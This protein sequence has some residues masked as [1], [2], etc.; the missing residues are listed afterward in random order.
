MQNMSNEL[1]DRKEIQRLQNEFCLAT[2]VGVCCLDGN[3]KKITEISGT[4]E[5]IERI[6]KYME[7]PQVIQAI[8]RIQEGFLED[9]AVEELNPEGDRVAVAAVRVK[10]VTLCNWVVFSL[11]QDGGDRSQN[12]LHVVDLLRDTS[13]ALYRHKAT[14]F[15]EDIDSHI[16]RSAGREMSRY[17][18]TIE[19]ADQMIQLL[20]SDEREEGILQKWLGILSE[21][22]QVDTAQLYQSNSEDGTMDVLCEWLA[23]G[24]MSIYDR[25]GKLK[26]PRYLRTEKPM[27]ISSDIADAKLQKYLKEWKLLALIQLPVIRR[28][29]NE[30]IMLSLNHRKRHIWTEQ[31]IQFAENAVR[32]LN[33]ILTVRMQKNKIACGRQT[34]ET[35]MDNVGSAVYVTDRETGEMLFAN[36]RLQSVFGKELAENTFEGMLQQRVSKGLDSSFFEVHQAQTERWYDLIVKE[37]VWL[38]GKDA[39][40]YALYDITDKKLFQYRIEQ[41]MYMDPMTGLNNRMCCERD[42]AHLIDEAKRSGS[43]GALLYMDLD[44]F[45][46]INDGLGHRYGDALLKTI[47]QALRRVSGVENTCYRMGGDEFVILIPPEKYSEYDRIVNDICS[48]FVRPWFLKEADYYCTMSMGSVIFPDQGDSVTELIKKAD[49]SMYEAKKGGKNRIVNYNEGLIIGSGWRLDM[50]KNMRDATVE[51]YDEFEVYF[52]PIIDVQNGAQC[53]G[54]E[55]LIRWNSEK[56]GF[57]SPTEFIPL[58]EYLG[59]INPIGNYV[60]KEACA[61]CRKWNESGY[62]EY[63]VNVNLSVVQLLQPDVV[64][65]VE[66]TIKETGINPGNLTLEL[67]E[68]LV[69]NDMV[70]MKE[71]MRR[72]KELGVK[73]ALDD[74]GTGYSSLNHIREIPFDVIKLDQSFVKDLTK[75]AYSQSFVKMVTELAGTLD[76]KICVEGIETSEQYNVLRDMNVKYIQGFYFDQ[77]LKPSEFEEKYV[78]KRQENV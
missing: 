69:I 30:T 11:V 28:E 44:D 17:L 45:V 49:I 71:V 5:Q 76:V 26:T 56:L 59:L 9:Q 64:E 50:E 23:P 53:A 58:A 39:N 37:I 47:A 51:G 74:F 70:H 35:L 24:Q 10:G 29:N 38:N 63:K 18:Q 16:S 67:T 57:I 1:I 40:L 14:R 6:E 20:D 22:L 7:L 61:Q 55:A 36:K 78:A 43:K 8:E 21:Y 52:Q 32:V 19:A 42:L 4:P 15:R 25:T 68:S 62:P 41:Q 73:I 75:D 3:G 72:I 65:L 60:L 31:E 48:F 46:H 66:R 12:F 27:V 54:A 34:L 2:G 77:P 13:H 33:S